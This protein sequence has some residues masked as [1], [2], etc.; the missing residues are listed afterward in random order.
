MQF[1]TKITDTLST[2][3][4]EITY[5]DICLVVV[6]PIAKIAQDKLSPPEK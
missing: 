1:R 6:L 3:E 5:S 2:N 4:I